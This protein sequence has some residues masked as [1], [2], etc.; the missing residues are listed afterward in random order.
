MPSKRSTHFPHTTGIDRA[1]EKTTA[2]DEIDAA[3]INS[4]VRADNRRI[5]REMRE[6][7]REGRVKKLTFPCLQKTEDF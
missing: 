5:R 4:R 3:R 2:D 7:E 6:T 1:Y